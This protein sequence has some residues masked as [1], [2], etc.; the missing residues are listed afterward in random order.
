MSSLEPNYLSRGPIS[1]YHHIEGQSFNM[2]FGR[3]TFQ[4]MTHGTGES[5]RTSEK[6]IP[7]G[8]LKVT[9]HHFYCVLCHRS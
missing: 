6:S 5:E 4:S 2:D 8:S 9:S 1:R 3:D 7:K